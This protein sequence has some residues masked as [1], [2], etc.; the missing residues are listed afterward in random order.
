MPQGS[1]AVRSTNGLYL[2]PLYLVHGF[3]KERPATVRHCISQLG[4]MITGISS[5]DLFH[6]LNVL[7]PFTSHKPLHDTQRYCVIFATQSSHINMSV[8]TFTIFDI[9]YYIENPERQKFHCRNLS[10]YH[11]IL[12]QLNPTCIFVTYLLI[13]M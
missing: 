11:D 7:P 5:E 13:G 9:N 2:L 6:H 12:S 3:L 1:S 8:Q 10:C 4:Y